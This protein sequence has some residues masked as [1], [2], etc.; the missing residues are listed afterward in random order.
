MADIVNTRDVLLQA[1]SPRVVPVLIPIDQI[2]GLPEAIKSLSI[3]ATDDTFRG[4]TGATTPTTITLT[5]KKSGGLTGSVSWTVISG[6]ATLSTSG[7]TCTIT[8]STVTGNRV[9]IKA[10]VTSG[11]V[12]YD[13]QIILNKLGTLS[14][15]EAVNLASQITG[16][17]AN[18][19]V[20][21]LRALAL[22]DSVS[23]SN[24]LQVFGDLAAQRIGAGQLA[25]GVIYAGTINVDNLVGST[26]SGKNLSGTDFIYI[27][28]TGLTSPMVIQKV[29]ADEA[30]VNIKGYFDVSR[31]D[32]Q[33]S[34]T[35]SNAGNL[36]HGNISLG[37]TA[38]FRGSSFTVRNE[39]IG[40]PT[41]QTSG[42]GGVILRHNSI[43]MLNAAGTGLLT[44]NSSRV[45]VQTNYLN[46]KVLSTDP[47]GASNG[48]IAVF[49]GELVVRIGGVWY[50]LT[51]TAV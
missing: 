4:L 47:G 26:I 7:D 35:V 6:S 16:Q 3:T 10:S 39:A 38:E 18:S 15:Q 42:A 45:S 22:L 43:Q 28:G 11:S 30:R 2:E 44:L 1:A 33:S 23:L 13:A 17:L 36:L 21:G 19:N 31:T 24:P 46:L 37:V 25:A 14:G 50:K 40:Y 48:D 49:A 51:K 27:G 29:G 34:F 5:A 20:S 32:L 8:G 41:L 9:T 12:N